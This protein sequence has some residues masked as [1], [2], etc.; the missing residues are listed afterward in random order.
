[1]FSHDFQ[2]FQSKAIFSVIELSGTMIRLSMLL[3]L[4]CAAGAVWA[5]GERAVI[6]HNSESIT[7]APILYGIEKG[8][9]RN[10]G[11]QLEFRF[12]RTDLAAAAIAA[13]GCVAIGY[14]L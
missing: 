12:L 1:M 5:Q 8:F 9:Y 6:S 3:A 13:L 4:L 7:I 14:C 2:S 11:I 10:E